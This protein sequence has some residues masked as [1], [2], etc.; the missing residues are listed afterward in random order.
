MTGVLTEGENLDT[1]KDMHGREKMSCEG[2]GLE[3]QIY[4]QNCASGQQ[5]T[6][7]YGRGMEQTLPTA[8]RKKQPGLLFEDTQY[9]GLCYRSPRKLTQYSI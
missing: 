1:D 2:R 6:R 3:R 8:F 9:A 7:S 4:V 5:T